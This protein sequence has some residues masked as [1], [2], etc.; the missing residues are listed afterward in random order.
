MA[1]IPAWSELEIAIVG[2]DQGDG[3]LRSTRSYCYLKNGGKFERDIIAADLTFYFHALPSP[4]IDA[5][6]HSR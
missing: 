1:G 6:P 4:H 5:N 3:L 2:V